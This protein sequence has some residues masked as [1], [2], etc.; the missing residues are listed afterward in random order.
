MKIQAY[1]KAHRSEILRLWES[2]VLATHDFLVQSDFLHI[3]DLLKE[4]DFS[5]IAVYG[6][7]EDSLLLG[8]VGV[9]DRKIEM[10]FI[11]PEHHGKGYGKFLT[12]FA[13]R[14]LGANLVDV[15]EGNLSA[16]GFYKALGFVQYDRSPTDSLGLAYP[17]L[18]LKR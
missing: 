4:F 15:N 3:K 5:Q 16:I 1:S 2:S 14:E 9:E 13:I 7:W 12:L 17:I 11:D 6:L 8:F 10:L 18:H